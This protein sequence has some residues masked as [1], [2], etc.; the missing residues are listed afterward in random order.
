MTEAETGRTAMS[1]GAARRVVTAARS[2][3]GHGQTLPWSLQKGP[4]QSLSP[5]AEPEPG[6]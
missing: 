1:Q 4:A 6:V 2:P 3:E 5:R